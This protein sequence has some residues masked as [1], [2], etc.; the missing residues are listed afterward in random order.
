VTD[1]RETANRESAAANDSA[2]EEK[3]DTS[4][5]VFAEV[6]LGLLRPNTTEQIRL[7]ASQLDVDL[8][9]N[10]NMDQEEQKSQN[11][12]H[13]ESIEAS[14]VIAGPGEVVL[15]RS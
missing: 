15:Q 7:S 6:D 3:T 4:A 8:H 10:D 12:E 9:G 2:I 1:A 14:S 13:F 11:N 5:T